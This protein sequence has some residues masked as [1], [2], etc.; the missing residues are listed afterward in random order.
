M[1][2]KTVRASS[3][4]REIRI[5]YKILAGKSERQEGL[6]RI[7]EFVLKKSGLMWAEFIWLRTECNDRA[8]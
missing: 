1:W 5:S 3:T 2:D 8:L 7:L 6:S 4:E